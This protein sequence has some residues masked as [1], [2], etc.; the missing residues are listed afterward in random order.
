MSKPES[1]K[2]YIFDR[3]GNYCI[4]VIGYLDE[5]W[6]DRLGGLHITKSSPKDQ[7]T[8]TSLVGQLRDQAELSGVLNTLYEM[9]LTLRSV[10]YLDSD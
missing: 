6:S 10:A 4:R 5:S 7:G 9:H 8:V 1:S 3:P 2:S